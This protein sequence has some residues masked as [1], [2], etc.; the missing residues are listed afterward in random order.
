MT[1]TQIPGTERTVDPE[2]E[3][4]A[5]EVR[6]RGAEK[7]DATRRL[8]AAEE[9]LLSI[10][11]ARTPGGTELLAKLAE[12]RTQSTFGYH[13]ADGIE[14]ESVL[15]IDLKPKVHK[16]GESTPQVGDGVDPPDDETD[17]ETDDSAAAAA[18]QLDAGVAEDEDGDVV[19]PEKTANPRKKAKSKKGRR[20]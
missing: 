10:Q 14:I 6:A 5:E 19:P 9:R 7:A 2:L 4:A 15:K 17:D 1:Q 3:A 18:A 11:I 8:R 12:L 20:K 16:T 13:D